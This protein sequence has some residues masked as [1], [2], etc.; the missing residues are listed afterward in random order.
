MTD[1][2]IVTPPLGHRD[3]GDRLLSIAE[4]TR[5]TSRGK[6][7]IMASVRAGSFPTPVKIAGRLFWSGREIQEWIESRLAERRGE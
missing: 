4:V 2:Y 1:Q 5:V 7:W 3:H 6:T